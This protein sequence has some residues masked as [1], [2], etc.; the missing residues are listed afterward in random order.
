MSAP[1]AIL[2]T[3]PVGSGKT[4]VLYALDEL[5]AERPEP[6]AVVDLDWLSWV[7]P[8]ADT[9]TV[10]DALRENLAALRETYRRAGVGRFVLSRAV[11]TREEVDEIAEALTGAEIL[12]VRL[13]VPRATLEARLSARDSGAQLAEH[14]AMLDEAPAFEAHEIDADRPAADVAA[15]ILRRAGW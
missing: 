15:E 9:I 1:H 4:T 11:A 7:R 10:R 14:L 6:Y 12:V 13:V 8:A 3:G 2:V 5:L